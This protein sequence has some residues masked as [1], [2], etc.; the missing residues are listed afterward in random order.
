MSGT[1]QTSHLSKLPKN[2]TPVTKKANKDFFESLDFENKQDY[3]DADRGLI[4][5]CEN[6]IENLNIQN[7]PS[8]DTVNPSLWRNVQL[9]AKSGL[10]KVVEGVY[11]VRGLSLATVIFVEG[12]SGVIVIDTSSSNSAADAAIELYFSHRPK[13]PVTA[14][15]ISQSHADHFGGTHS[16]L[17]YAETSTIPIIVPEHFTQEMFS[18]NVLL[19]PIMSRR[20]SY[21]FGIG[22]PVGE[23]G[24][25]SAGIGTVFH[26]GNGFEMPNREIKEEIEQLTIDGINFEFLLTPNTEA[27]AEMHFYIQDYKV[28]FVSENVNKTMHQIYTIRGAK[29]RDTLE[30][31]KAIDKTIELSISKEIDALVMAHAWPVWGKEQAFEHLVLQRDLYKYIHD[32]TIRLA[33]HGYTMEEIAEELKLPETLDQYWG[34]RGYYGTL[35]HNSKG[36]YNFYLGYYSG[37]P[38]DL[39]PLPQVESGQKYVSYMGGSAHVVKQAKA[40]F[41]NGQY[42]WV[43]QVLKHVVMAEPDNKEAK[44]LLADTFEQLGYQAESANWRNSYLIGASELRNGTR[45]KGAIAKGHSGM[46]LKMPFDEFFK[47]LSVRLNGP[48]AADK[49]I[50]MN[51]SLSDVE[52][53]YTI[54]LENC[55]LNKRNK[56]DDNPDLSFISNKATFYAIV[57]GILDPREAVTSNKLELFGDQ[58]KL[59]EFLNLL[60]HF[61]QFVNIVTP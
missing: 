29:T 11:Q 2:A 5:P 43:A 9:Q 16:I 27:P 51:V 37:H 42:R 18:E 21:Q 36:I 14:I 54:Y 22:L 1:V 20:A 52:E 40:D 12:K 13:R 35:K 44:E 30:W 61:D 47:L 8:P 41:E 15:I 46:M 19:G 38:S 10:Y 32:Q 48:K 45:K 57:S 33:N 55:V 50:I 31:V 23:Q 39:E 53:K 60:D 56:L 6:R 58:T 17:Q 59:D 25:L 24:F 26:S 4:A 3:E 49:K 34:N 28:L 7:Q